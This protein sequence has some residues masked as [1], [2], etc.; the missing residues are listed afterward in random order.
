MARVASDHDVAVGDPTPDGL[1]R[2]LHGLV[3]EQRDSADARIRASGEDGPTANTIRLE[4]YV[5]G[6]EDAIVALAAEV[7]RL[8][9]V[10][11]VGNEAAPAGVAPVVPISLAPAVHPTPLRALGSEEMPSE[12]HFRRDHFAAPALDPN[13]WRLLI[14]G[15]VEQPVELTLNDLQALA[16]R[17][18]R[19]VLECAGHRRGEFSPPA[20]GLP[21]GVGAL[22]EAVWQGA[23]LR[24]VLALAG[25]RPE[26]SL[27]VLEGADSGQFRDHPQPVSFARALPLNKA[28]DPDTL[29]AWTMNGQP[30]PRAHGA[31]LRAIVP[32]WYATDSVKWL[33]RISVLERPFT[34]LFEAI[35]YR[36]ADKTI[37]GGR[38]LTNLPVHAIIT[39][40]PEG[41]LVA[42]G[43]VELRGIA[44]GGADIAAVEVSI[45]GRAW[46]P[47]H[48]DRHRGR[49]ARTF[50]R[51]T[52]EASAGDH[53]I[54]VRAW[55]SDNNT[56]PE[57]P[58]WNER[59][60]GN[61]SIQ[62]QQIT[63]APTTHS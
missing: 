56:Q 31:P 49:Y 15:A 46:Q 60:Y 10:G 61:A 37:P 6:L 26:A 4:G 30:L 19:A 13:S 20:A 54:A 40:P 38:R 59:G 8:A 53:T 21:W 22:G 42:S 34:G 18:L 28:L 23:S 36:L 2:R 5:R 14:D 25:L 43:T 57:R 41:A 16:R 11:L 62:R 17:T 39:S 55:D 45:D 1:A 58:E 48:L 32:G 9:R 35:D 3:R 44:W 47:A 24:D 27:V 52:W 7:E 50:W 33:S 63:V 12:A 51:A 29:L